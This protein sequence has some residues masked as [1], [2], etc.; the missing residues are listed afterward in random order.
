M[1]AIDKTYTSKWEEYKEYRD[2]A[3]NQKFVCP[4]GDVVKPIDYLIKW[5]EED[6]DGVH[7]KPIMNTP[8]TLDYFL[9]K[10]C[11]V[12]F[13]YDRLREVEPIEIHEYIFR[14]SGFCVENQGTVFLADFKCDEFEIFVIPNSL[15]QG[16]YEYILKV[17]ANA[18]CNYVDMYNLRFVHELQHAIRLC[19]INFEVKL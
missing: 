10:H 19:G 12:K 8:Y 3:I 9:I 16:E 6:F 1:A 5:R 15:G 2:W 11:P 13:V 18:M 14:I 17:H 4:N 7:E